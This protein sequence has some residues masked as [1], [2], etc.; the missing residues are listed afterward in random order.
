MD[1]KEEVNF[2]CLHY[3]FHFVQ[4]DGGKHIDFVAED[5]SVD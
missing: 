3:W 5:N 1:L 2:S 4:P